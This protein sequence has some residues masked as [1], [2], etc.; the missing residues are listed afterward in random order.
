MK[1]VPQ[2]K[3]IKAAFKA[4]VK[5]PRKASLMW[6]PHQSSLTREAIRAIVL[7]QIG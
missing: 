3:P 5:H 7:E 1:T 6:Q 2:T 4:L